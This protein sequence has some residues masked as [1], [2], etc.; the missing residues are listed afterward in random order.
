MEYSI[1]LFIL[2]L[3][4][5]GFAIRMFVIT[6]SQPN[7]TGKRPPSYLKPTETVE[8]DR[9]VHVKGAEEIQVTRAIQEFC[10]IHNYDQF[11]AILTLNVLSEEEFVITFPYDVDFETFC[12]FV[13]YLHFAEADLDSAE[14]KGWTTTDSKDALITEEIA[15][16][17]VMIYVPEDEDQ[18]DNVHLV[19]SD[20]VGYKVSFD[21]GEET[22]MLEQPEM[23]YEEPPVDPRNLEPESSV[24]FE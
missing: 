6:A 3:L 5:I 2:V 11:N 14:I 16:K 1:F 23:H 18:T 9:L 15:G 10:N 19:T 20:D 7:Q 8:N 4:A 17:P 12:V 13:N 21:D 22:Q 24:E